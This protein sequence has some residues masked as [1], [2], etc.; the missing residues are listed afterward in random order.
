[1]NNPACALRKKYQKKGRVDQREKERRE[2]REI[3]ADRPDRHL[4]L[5][6]A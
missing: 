5:S 4:S 1:M 2:V 6:A 3:R